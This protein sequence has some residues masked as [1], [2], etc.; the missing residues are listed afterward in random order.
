MTDQPP[1]ITTTTKT[2]VAF[3]HPLLDII[4][5][6]DN[7]FLDKYNAPVGATMLATPEQEHL[8]DDISQHK[9]V[10]Y[11][12]GGAAMNTTRVVH[13]MWKNKCKCYFVG[14][15]AEDNFG[16]ILRD[17][18][19]KVNVQPLF[20]VCTTKPSGT[21]ACLVVG[22]ERTL[23]A[24]LGAALHLS[25]D[26]V[27]NDAITDVLKKADVVYC[28]GFFLNL[29]ANPNVV[30][31][32]ADYCCTNDVVL[33]FNL[34]APYLC[35]IF[36]DL[37]ADVMP[38]IDVIFGNKVDFCAYAETLGWNDVADVCEIAMRVAMLPK[39]NNSRSRIVVLTHG[40]EPTVVA[41]PEGIVEYE[42]PWVQLDQI[43]DLNGAGDAFA[44]GFLSAYV[45][46]QTIDE[47]MKAAQHA[48]KVVI[49]Q[50]GCT[51]PDTCE[52][53]DL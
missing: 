47:C 27:K 4:T 51:L 5:H 52:Y 37:W 8:F 28:E 11:V 34:S 40:E 29:V 13:W 45:A 18:L 44:G 36:K 30:M 32:V 43:V 35:H 39:R 3:G 20:D 49:R 16:R 10:Q 46:D 50:K 15:T 38:C 41:T 33:S 24:N 48:A 14:C 31:Y 6:V 53:A 9:D 25:L 23:V 42:T 21:C 12:P 1:V 7:D 17:A 22:K 19:V 2:F 26:F